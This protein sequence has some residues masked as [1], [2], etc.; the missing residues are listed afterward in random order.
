MSN[1]LVTFKNIGRLVGVTASIVLPT[2]FAFKP[3]NL[4][5]RNLP[6]KV[7]DVL[8]GNDLIVFLAP[9]ITAGGILGTF[10][11]MPVKLPDKMSIKYKYKKK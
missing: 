5:A 4:L 2:Y 11:A 3:N 6:K 1:Q 8:Y 9:I 10:G 7:H